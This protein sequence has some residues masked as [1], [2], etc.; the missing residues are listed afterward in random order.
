MSPRPYRRGQRKGATEQTRVRIVEAARDLLAGAR[1][2]AAL[3]IDAVAHH[4]GVARMTVYYQFG[5]KAGLLEALFDHLAIRGGMNE[6]AS[7]FHSP[8]PLASL[9]QCIAVF[10]HFWDTDRLVT[11]RL[12]SLAALDPVIEQ[13]V[14]A[15]DG[16]RTE[17]MRT[18]VGRMVQAYGR[19]A[20]AAKDDTIDVLAIITGFSTFDALATDARSTEDVIHLLRVAAR[21]LLGLDGTSQEETSQVS[22]M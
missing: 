9:D 3:S 6:M 15:R 12:R 10:A 4:A 18:I 21:A 16:R 19:P 5:S 1:G 22:K 7:V 13:G 20:P 8:E 2:V 17:I 14:V 11:R